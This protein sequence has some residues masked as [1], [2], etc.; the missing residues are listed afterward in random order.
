[1][2][3]S[4]SSHKQTAVKSQNNNPVTTLYLHFFNNI[5]KPWTFFQQQAD[6]PHAGDN[7]ISSFC[8]YSE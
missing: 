7:F 8:N 1:M 4:Y 3:K 6:E 2:Q 5:P